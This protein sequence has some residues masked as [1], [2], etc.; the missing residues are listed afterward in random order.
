MKKTFFYQTV[1]SIFCLFLLGCSN[2]KNNQEQET[3]EKY[4]LI[5]AD[6]IM[7]ESLEGIQITDYN[8]KTQR[9]LAFGIQTKS[10]LEIDIKGKIISKVNLS[11]EGPGNFGPGMDGLG[12]IDD[13]F[14]IKG[15]GK[16]LLYDNDWQFIDNFGFGTQSIPL[17]YISGAPITYT[18]GN[19]SFIVDGIDQNAG[20]YI[21][22][23]ND[24][25]STAKMIDLISSEQ[26]EVQQMIEYP[27][28]SIYKSTETFYASCQPIMDF[29]HSQEQLV[30]SLPLEEKIYIYDVSRGFTLSKVLDLDLMGFHEPKGIPFE[31]QQKNSLKGFGPQNELNYVYMM[32]NSSI[33]ELS[34]IKDF[35][36]VRHKTGVLGNASLSSY[37]EASELAEKHSRYITTFL[38][39]GKKILETEEPLSYII[40]IDNFRFLSHYINE[41]E[42]TDYAK[43]Y[44]YE[45]QKTSAN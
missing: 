26:E 3:T 29:N 16:Y 40:P 9:F 43:Y 15:F 14:L 5:K 45:L 6:S 41:D 7:V 32:I 17:F 22:L 21:K 37:R 44:I 23:K 33:I 4:E 31:D 35:I 1:C 24:H 25:F 10:C 18:R 19:E 27:E 38:H 39:Q 28:G 8:P 30:L 13:L 11:G 34:S 42:E 36:V 20:G 2:S 12:Y